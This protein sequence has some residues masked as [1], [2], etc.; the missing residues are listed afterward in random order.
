[1]RIHF[2]T[3]FISDFFVLNFNENYNLIL[4]FLFSRL[5]R[6]AVVV[7]E[8]TNAKQPQMAQH[9]RKLHQLQQRKLPVLQQQLLLLL[10]QQLQQHQMPQNQPIQKVKV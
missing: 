2:Y 5:Q 4:I 3:N 9:L 1:M 6:Q 8:R 10:L 7:N